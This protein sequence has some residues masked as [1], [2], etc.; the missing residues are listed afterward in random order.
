MAQ[1]YATPISHYFS[2]DRLLI[3]LKSFVPLD[4]I[5]ELNIFIKWFLL[6]LTGSSNFQTENLTI[7]FVF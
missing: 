4:Q 5:F 1:L 7:L 3:I 2:T 6:F